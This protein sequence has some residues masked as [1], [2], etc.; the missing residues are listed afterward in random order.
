MKYQSRY[1]RKLVVLYTWFCLLAN[2]V[3]I[4]VSTGADTGRIREQFMPP[5]GKGKT[6]KLTWS[7]EF[8][9]TNIDTSKW[10]IL[11]DWKRRDGYWV[12][13]DS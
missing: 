2:A 7:D 3:S 11:G 1:I 12:K 9:G 6:W 4:T 13:E 5:A 10:E 8:N